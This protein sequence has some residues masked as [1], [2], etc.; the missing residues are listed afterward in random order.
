MV[1][2]MESGAWARCRRAWGE[3]NGCV[4]STGLRNGLGKLHVV[5]EYLNVRLM[6]WT[7]SE[8]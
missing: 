3:K 8:M 5:L 2:Q 7:V 4:G 6:G 1:F